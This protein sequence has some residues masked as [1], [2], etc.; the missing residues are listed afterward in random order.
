MSVELKTPLDILEQKD[1]AEFY[2]QVLTEREQGIIMS[3]CSGESFVKTGRMLGLSGARVGQ[4]TK[5]SIRRLRKLAGV[6]SHVPE[7]LKL[8]G[9]D[10]E[11]RNLG[12]AETAQ[13]VRLKTQPHRERKPRKPHY[14]GSDNHLKELAKRHTPATAK[15]WVAH[16]WRNIPTEDKNGNVVMSKPWNDKWINSHVGLEEV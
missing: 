16:V 9:L 4:I 2:L 10:R 8:L 5:K 13:G 11:Y 1:L 12:N 3:W 6:K 14:M 7:C 15:P